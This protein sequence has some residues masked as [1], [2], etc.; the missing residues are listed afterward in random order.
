MIMYGH[1][2]SWDLLIK[3]YKLKIDDFNV[4]N[5]EAAIYCKN[6]MDAYLVEA[7]ISD[8][9]NNI[10]FSSE[11][12]DMK[13]AYEI[14][15]FNIQFK[16]TIL[17][18][19]CFVFYKKN[20]VIIHANPTGIYTA[21]IIEKEFY[22]KQVKHMPAGVFPQTIR[23]FNDNLFVSDSQSIHVLPIKKKWDGEF[24]KY[25]PDHSYLLKWE[26]MDVFQIDMIFLNTGYEI[27][28]YNTTDNEINK[29]FSCKDHIRSMCLSG[30]FLFFLINEIGY[31]MDVNTSNPEKISSSELKLDLLCC[32][33]KSL[34]GVDGDSIYKKDGDEFILVLKLEGIKYIFPI[35]EDLLLFTADKMLILTDMFVYRTFS[36]H[37]LG[38][39]KAM[40][41]PFPLAI[42]PIQKACSYL[43][44]NQEWIGNYLLYKGK[45]DGE[46]GG[47]PNISLSSLQNIGHD[48][49]KLISIMNNFQVDTNSIPF[50]NLTTISLEH[51]FSK[52][53]LGT[54]RNPSFTT[55]I[56]R[57]TNV[58]KLEEIKIN[59]KNRKPPLS[60][61]KLS[62]E[63]KRKREDDSEDIMAL[64]K[65]QR[66]IGKCNCLPP[67]TFTKDSCGRKPFNRLLF[68]VKE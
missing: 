10:L 64:K 44:E 9:F 30:N 43:K 23:V 21:S 62:D 3:R 38:L 27:Y 11:E 34:Y 58:S 26:E 59:I 18:N 65:L 16:T 51:Y 4:R 56:Q 42:E 57:I 7:V 31:K 40:Y 6:K 25:T 29:I 13:K 49:G 1:W 36:S 19:G 60:Y 52:L 54:D 46:R 48:L 67:T 39:W 37:M 32:N 63:R 53:R 20:L 2:F 28:Y 47:F 50:Y 55:A 5:V 14:F 61:Q 22:F 45:I 15:Q 33:N 41:M 68:E 66:I 24:V 12:F 8:E 17:L 35:M